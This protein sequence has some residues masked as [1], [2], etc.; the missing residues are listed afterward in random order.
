LVEAEDRF[1]FALTAGD[2]DGDGHD[3][4]AVGVPY[5][6]RSLTDTGIVQIL[7]GTASGLTAINDQLWCQD[8]PGVLGTEEADDRFGYA[9]AAIPTVRHK[10]FLPAVLREY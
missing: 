7:W 2:F 6:H 5:E 9:L 4:L 10:I 1:G 8:S 3:D